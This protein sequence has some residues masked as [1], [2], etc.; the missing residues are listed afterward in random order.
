M[1]THSILSLQL[2]EEKTPGTAEFPV[3]PGVVTLCRLTELDGKFKMLITNGEIEKSDDKLR[4]SWSWVRV[5][6]LDILY[7][8]L[9]DEGF[10]HHASMIHGDYAQAI[11]DA[12]MFLKIDT[13]IV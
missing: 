10:T 4:G 6:D 13:V 5:P 11:E 8:T 7:S 12:C 2:G 9:V 1:R 3:K